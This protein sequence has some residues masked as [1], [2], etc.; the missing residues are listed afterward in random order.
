MVFENV[1]LNPINPTPT[2]ST[3][4]SHLSE[5]VGDKTDLDVD[6][7]VDKTSKRTLTG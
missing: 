1:D 7:N 4:S 6:I 3:F 2:F 5:N